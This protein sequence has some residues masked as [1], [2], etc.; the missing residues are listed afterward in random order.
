MGK[1]MIN[2]A[3]NSKTGNI[4]IRNKNDVQKLS[5][6][7]QQMLEEGRQERLKD[8]I[9]YDDMLYLTIMLCNITITQL[10]R[11]ILKKAR[12]TC[13]AKYNFHKKEIKDKI[14]Q[15]I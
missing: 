3:L 7:S 12:K 10:L 9:L 4:Y 5:I 6:N 13:I 14:K 15:E 11:L 8:A 1:K 2:K